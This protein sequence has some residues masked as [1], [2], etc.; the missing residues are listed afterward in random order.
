MKPENI[1]SAIP[2]KLEKEAFE[3]LVS[4]SV[5]TIEKIISKGHRSP[6][7]G[8]YD[9]EKNEWV[10]VLKGS[11]ELTFAD[12]TLVRLEEGDFIHI[13]PHK[14]HRVSWTDPDRETFWLAVHY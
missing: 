3:T 4:S 12:K 13:P 10:L 7:G 8:W 14:K 11:A 1:F 5:V 6:D 2:V 9:Q